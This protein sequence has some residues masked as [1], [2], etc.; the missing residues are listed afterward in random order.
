[1]QDKPPDPGDLWQQLQAL[2]LLTETTGALQDGQVL[3]LKLW[4]YVAA[5]HLKRHE[6]SWDPERKLI[7]YSFEYDGRKK[8]SDDYQQRLLALDRSVKAMLGDAWGVR[9]SVAGKAIFTSGTHVERKRIKGN[10]SVKRSGA[11]RATKRSR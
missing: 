10:K 2:R 6:F 9:V 4:P 3:Q 7:E 11:K 1:M 5:S 8:E